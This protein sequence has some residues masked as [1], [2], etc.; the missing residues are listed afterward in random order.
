MLSSPFVLQALLLLKERYTELS[1]PIGIVFGQYTNWTKVKDTVKQAVWDIPNEL[2]LA[3]HYLVDRGAITQGFLLTR[4]FYRHNDTVTNY[5]GDAYEQLFSFFFLTPSTQT[6]GHNAKFIR[7]QIAYAQQRGSF[8]IGVGE[9]IDPD[10][11]YLGAPQIY[12]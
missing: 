3:I 8:V 6:K 5:N 12:G 1:E 11:T 2:M 9:T 7:M 10:G 4:N